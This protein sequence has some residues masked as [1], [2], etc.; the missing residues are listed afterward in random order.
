MVEGRRVTVCTAAGDRVEG[1]VVRSREET[2]I[3]SVGVARSSGWKLGDELEVVPRAVAT[4]SHGS[5]AAVH[6]PASTRF[7]IYSMY[8]ALGADIVVLDLTRP[9]HHHRSSSR[10]ARAA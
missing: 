10:R 9:V 4:R 2:L 8:R 7:R 1:S 6:P 5:G 3:V